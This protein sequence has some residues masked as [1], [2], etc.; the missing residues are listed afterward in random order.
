MARLSGTT[1]GLTNYYVPTTWAVA[2]YNFKE[3]MKAAGA[4]VPRSS[5]GTTY[6]SSGDQITSGGSGAGGFD[7]ARAWFV[8]SYAGRH[9]C[10][11]RQNTTGAN[12]SRSIRMKYSFSAGFSGGSPAATVTPS[13]TDEQILLGGGSDASPTFAS[14]IGQTDGDA[15]VLMMVETA[16]PYGFWIAGYR[17][18]L[19]ET[20][21][22]FMFTPVTNPYYTDAD[23]YAH[24]IGGAGVGGGSSPWY[25]VTSL[26]LAGP[27]WGAWF[28]KGEGSEAWETVYAIAP[29]DK[30][31]NS[32]GPVSIGANPYNSKV[33]V[34]PVILHH[35]TSANSTHYGMKGVATLIQWNGYAVGRTTYPALGDTGTQ[36]T[37]RDRVFI[38]HANLAW[39]GETIT[40][41][42]TRD[43]NEPIGGNTIIVMQGGA[44]MAQRFKST[45]NIEITVPPFINIL[46][47]LQITTGSETVTVNYVKPDASTGSSTATWNSTSK[48]WYFSVST[49]S[50]MQGLWRFSFSSSDA[51]THLQS[52]DVYWGGYVE[53]ID[54]TI[55]SRAASSALTTA[56]TDITAIK[57]KTD[58]LPSDPADES[59][60]E[61]A[62][63]AA[64]A[65][66]KGGD[67]RDLTEVYD[68]ADD[69][70]VRLGAPAGLSIAAD[71][72]DVQT[73]A[74]LVRKYMTNKKEIV[75]SGPDAN[76]EIVYDDNG[77]SVLQKF[78]LFDQLGNPTTG[79]TIFSKEPV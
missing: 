64:V 8:L 44:A 7:N 61:A 29:R 51:N 42:T 4:T 20:S 78:D 3:L 41:A 17:T 26:G 63:T 35:S 16:A 68:K 28:K 76:R 73:I 25:D 36:R 69:V 22:G 60:V 24:Y 79:P 70:Y 1:I 30:D 54:D 32:S 47:G 33:D 40:G 12:T 13:A 59:Q 38:G 50:Y 53:N 9:W 27:T 34:I 14:W 10:F 77:T 48:S 31:I 6:N 23:P 72:S 5:D 45:E 62:I 66:I 58:N 18:N 39:T 11:Q 75:D 2:L 52:R 19:G 56:Q 49:G 57:A 43:V 65:S 55:S 37:T 21:G 67:S 15:R 74:D 71:I 46:N